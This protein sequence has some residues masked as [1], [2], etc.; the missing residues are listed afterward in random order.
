MATDMDR[1][2]KGD[3]S[4]E[5]V[6]FSGQVKL[7][8]MTYERLRFS[9]MAIPAVALGMVLYY[10]RDHDASMLMAWG[11]AYVAAAIAS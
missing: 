9:I 6:S 11:L 3:A 7:L 2:S 4:L 1:I 8:E 10:A 5:S